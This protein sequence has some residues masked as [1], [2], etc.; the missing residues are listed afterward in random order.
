VFSA[1][2]SKKMLKKGDTV[3]AKIT[4][5]SLKPTLADTKIG[6]SMRP[7]GLGKDEWIEKDDKRSQGGEPAVK[8]EKKEHKE[9]P[10]KAKEKSD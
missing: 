2:E 1:K 4:T 5:V 6:L 10:K 3:Y 9:K 8:E 7:A